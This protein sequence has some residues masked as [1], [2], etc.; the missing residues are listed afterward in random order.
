MLSCGEAVAALRT[1][2]LGEPTTNAAMR[3]ARKRPNRFQTQACRNIRS[4]SASAVQGAP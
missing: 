4:A 3:F 1:F 2:L